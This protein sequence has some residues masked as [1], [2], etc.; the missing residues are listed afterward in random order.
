MIIQDNQT[1]F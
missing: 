1:F